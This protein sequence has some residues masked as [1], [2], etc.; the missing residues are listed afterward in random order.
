MSEFTLFVLSKLSDFAPAW[1]TSKLSL[2]SWDSLCNVLLMELET[3]ALLLLLA[4]FMVAISRLRS[5]LGILKIVLS[6]VAVLFAF[7]CHFLLGSA[8]ALFESNNK[9]YEEHCTRPSHYDSIAINCAEAR[10]VKSLG[11]SGNAFHAS[12]ESLENVF[13]LI[14]GGILTPL[15]I[16]A[17]IGLSIVVCGWTA[18]RIRSDYNKDM[19][20]VKQSAQAFDHQKSIFDAIKLFMASKQRDGRRLISGGTAPPSSSKKRRSFMDSKAMPP[21][22]KIVEILED[23]DNNN[24]GD[25]DDDD[26]DQSHGHKR[27]RK[28]EFVEED[29]LEIQGAD[30]N[31]EGDE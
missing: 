9:F 21:S 3:L 24:N 14:F 20:F 8:Q 19:A 1:V 27:G 28:R 11:V 22:K 6:F 25:N 18:Y 30:S 17:C 15:F 12:V 23:N 5:S 31:D 26:D 7:H 2:P 4:G 29:V 10:R 13:H 16:Q